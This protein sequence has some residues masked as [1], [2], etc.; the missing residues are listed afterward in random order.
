M[1]TLLL[2]S[3]IL[4]S[5]GRPLDVEIRPGVEQSFSATLSGSAAGLSEGPFRGALALN[6]S[7]AQ[8]SISGEARK[9]GSRWRLPVTL[10]YADVPADWANRFRPGTFDYRLRGT[11]AGG[12][13]V[14]WAGTKRW[15]GVEV[16]GDRDVVSRFVKLRSVEV[17]EFSLL[18]S[19]AKAILAVRNPFSFPLKLARTQYQ[20]S[21][22]GREVG[23]GETRG[24][25][26]RESQ[27]NTLSLPIELD[28]GELVAAAGRALL[29]GGTVEARLTGTLTIRLPGGD[30]A[31]PLDLSGGLSLSR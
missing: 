26:L 23:S 20:L 7:P 2:L 6:G 29:S 21:A 25:L 16:E 18:E 17:T 11:V 1:T 22:N 30:V 10:R 3:L 4:A 27:T 12:A 24:L 19:E 14:E 8:I 9:N 15:D 13:P 5:L 31:V 28:H